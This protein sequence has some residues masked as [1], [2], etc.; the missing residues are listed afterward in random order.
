MKCLILFLISFQLKA[1]TFV[2]VSDQ[3]EGK[4]FYASETNYFRSRYGRYGFGQVGGLLGGV[5]GFRGKSSGGYDVLYTG[6]PYKDKFGV[7]ATL[8]IGNMSFNWTNTERD[9]NYYLFGQGAGVGIV[10]NTEK[11]HFRIVSKHMAGIHSLS[12][13]R[14]LH[15]DTRYISGGQVFVG[16]KRLGFSYDFMKLGEDKLETYFVY[17]KINP[18]WGLSFGYNKFTFNENNDNIVMLINWR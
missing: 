14:L 16:L 15:P 8:E 11:I 2:G 9:Q 17:Y 1:G 3:S 12:D 13:K 18:T 4:S 5:N 7:T 6:H 10:A